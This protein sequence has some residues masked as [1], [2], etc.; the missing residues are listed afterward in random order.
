[1]FETYIVNASMLCRVLV[2]DSVIYHRVGAS[3]FSPGW[4][5][6]VYVPELALEGADLAVH[7]VG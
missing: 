5:M 3:A 7:G 4:V 6:E 2:P 1:M